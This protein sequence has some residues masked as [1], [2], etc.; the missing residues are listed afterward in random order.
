LP[1][2]CRRKA[3]VALCCLSRI[4]LLAAFVPQA[5]YALALMLELLRHDQ[6]LDGPV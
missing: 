3:A 5:T 4:A 1:L 6:S 2:G